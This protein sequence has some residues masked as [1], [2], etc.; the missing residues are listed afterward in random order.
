MLREGRKSRRG[1]LSS[2]LLGA[3]VITAI[4]GCNGGGSS[5]SGVAINGT[6]TT[7]VSVGQAY[8]FT[9][10]AQGSG[11][12]F[13]IQNKPSWADFSISTGQLGGTPTSANVGT[14]P[15][16]VITA[17][18]GAATASLA[19]FTINVSAG[20][21]ATLAWQAPT[22]NT[23]GTAVDNLAGYIIN[24]GQN[25]SAL[26]QSV[27]IGTPLTTKFTVNDLSSGTWYFAIVAYT[28]DGS[29]SSLSNIV[30]TTIQ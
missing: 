14:Y 9:P 24:Y 16:V 6:P 17:S 2:L 19:A 25:A 29:Q 7:Q 5:A 28:A 21:Q 23:D 13:S 20:G 1:R 18:N 3:L 12:S 10:S 15:N 22:E 26:S 30:S 11:L 27:N 4:S 8:S